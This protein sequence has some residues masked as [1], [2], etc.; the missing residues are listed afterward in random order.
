MFSAPELAHGNMVKFGI[1]ADVFG[2]AACIYYLMASPSRPTPVY[3]YSDIDKDLRLNL[4]MAH[5]SDK[6]A[7]AIIAGLQAVAAS[8]PADIQTFLNLFPGCEG[9][10]L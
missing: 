2:L 1:P 6:F 8:R 5:C 10:R 7:D 9:V 3:E 4:Q